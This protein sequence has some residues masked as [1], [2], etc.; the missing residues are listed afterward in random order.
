M[1]DKRSRIFEAAE[2]MFAEHGFDGTTTQQISDRADI[3]AGTLFRYAASKGELLLMVYNEKFR[4]A[5]EDGAAVARGRTNTTDA[6]FGMAEALLRGADP[7]SDN[8]IAYQRE[9]LFGS[10]TD[11][12]RSEGL[13]LVERLESMIAER[14]VADARRDGRAAES[15]DE[16]ASRR[17]EEQAALAGRSIFAVLHLAFAQPATGAHSGHDAPADLRAQIAQIIAGF[18]TSIG[19]QEQ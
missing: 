3:A 5:L 2:A 15:S 11:K 17:W 12:Y 10:P 6:V 8:T 7:R 18:N 13:A 19:R 14:L 1:H 4:A 9:L 16:I